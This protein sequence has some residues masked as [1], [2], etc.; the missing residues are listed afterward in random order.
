MKMNDQHSASRSF[1]IRRLREAI[2]AR[3]ENTSLRNVAREVGMSPT[4]L[5]K[6]LQGTSPYSPTLRR[7]R[8]WYVQYAGVSSG[9][10]EYQDAHAALNVLVHDLTPEA[11]RSTTH[12]FIECLAR[13]YNDSGKSPPSWIAELKVIDEPDPMQAN[14]PGARP[15][16]FGKYRGIIGSSTDYA[17]SKQEDIDLEDRRPAWNTFSTRAR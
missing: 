12:R 8:S 15:S 6:F 2:A 10:L 9:G 1:T 16:A 17:R 14:A 13:G 11:R 5:K 7:L 4:G 3:A